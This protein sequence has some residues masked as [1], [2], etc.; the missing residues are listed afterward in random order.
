MSDIGILIVLTNLLC[1]LS[2]ILK[3]RQDC[4]TGVYAIFAVFNIQL[5]LFIHVGPI[6][7]TIDTVLGDPDKAAELLVHGNNLVQH[8][9]RRT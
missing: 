6:H 4:L 2:Q 3:T 7:K 8:F 9:A 5:D 1:H